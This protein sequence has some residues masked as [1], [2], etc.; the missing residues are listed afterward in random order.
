MRD[1][2][3]AAKLRRRVERK[4]RL[5]ADAALQALRDS[6]PNCANA[7]VMAWRDVQ[8]SSAARRAEM[9]LFAARLV[10]KPPKKDPALPQAAVTLIA[11]RRVENPLRNDWI[12][13]E[14]LRELGI[15]PEDLPSIIDAD[16]RLVSLIGGLARI[17]RTE[18]QTLAAAR[19]RLLWE[20]SQIGGSKATDYSQAKVDVSGAAQNLVADIGAD[21]RGE[22][23]S[24]VQRLGMLKSQL[25]EEVVCRERTVRDLA[26]SLGEG[27]GGAG[28]ERAKGRLLDAVDVLAEHFGYDGTK[29]RRRIRGA[30]DV[31][32]SETGYTPVR[33]AYMVA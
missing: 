31:A 30:G 29:P 25:V 22:Y 32:S 10:P 27:Q 15:K 24:A 23:M 16:V 14:A 20:R 1:E 8:Q 33:R 21:A 28:F 2:R 6:D 13:E 18:G 26:R 9:R 5:A 4:E 17:G 7:H 3:F 11:K 12:V 19:Y